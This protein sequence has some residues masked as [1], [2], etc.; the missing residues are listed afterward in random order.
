MMCFNAFHSEQATID[1]IENTQ[2]IRKGQLTD[3]KIAAY[4]Q[5]MALAA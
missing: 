2:M 5:F 3:E 4:K 1:D